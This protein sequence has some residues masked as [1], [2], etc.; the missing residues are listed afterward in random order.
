MLL[1][2]EVAFVK[3]C[4]IKVSSISINE[5]RSSISPTTRKSRFTVFLDIARRLSLCLL[6]HRKKNNTQNINSGPANLFFLKLDDF[7][8]S[9]NRQ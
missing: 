3:K 6:Q 8:Y 4:G 1:N 7:T 2:A 9:R 5:L